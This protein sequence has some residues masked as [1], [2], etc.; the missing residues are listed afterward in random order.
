[1][2]PVTEFDQNVIVISSHEPARSIINQYDIDDPNLA[3]I[4]GTSS[5]RQVGYVQQPTVMMTPVGI[6]VSV[7]FV[8]TAARREG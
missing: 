2:S 3:S 1:V 5:Q 7:P 4:A 8:R 6:I